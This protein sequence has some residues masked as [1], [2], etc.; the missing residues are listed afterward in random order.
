MA[1]RARDS[2]VYAVNFLSG[3][4][5]R[6]G[7]LDRGSADAALK[8]GSYATSVDVHN[9]DAGRKVKFRMRAALFAPPKD[10]CGEL[11]S[12]QPAKRV[13]VELEPLGGMHVDG[14]FVRNMLLQ[15]RDTP[16]IAA[17]AF[18][19]GW[20]SIESDADVPLDVAAVHTAHGFVGGSPSGF[21]MQV[22]RIPSSSPCEP[23]K[24][25]KS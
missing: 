16:A 17:P 24:P 9:P 25:R 21:S 10:G 13:E 23:A 8:S 3:D 18:I 22:T 11:F 4:F 20:L 7:T 5:D 15:A 12:P 14:A 2:L 19:M 1:A 6:A